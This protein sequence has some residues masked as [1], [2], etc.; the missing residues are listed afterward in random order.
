MSRRGMMQVMCLLS[1]RSLFCMPSLAEKH[2]SLM[3]DVC[4]LGVATFS[5][6][7]LYRIVIVERPFSHSK[8]KPG[9]GASQRSLV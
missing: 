8:P 2:P 5:S 1:F 3:Q 6:C 7:L 4:V 9:T